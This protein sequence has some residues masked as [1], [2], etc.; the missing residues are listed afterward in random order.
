[1]NSDNS[2]SKLLNSLSPHTYSSPLKSRFNF[3][4]FNNV[5]NTYS[6]PM[7]KNN[8][9]LNKKSS[10][11]TPTGTSPAPALSTEVQVQ[12][13][14][15]GLG[16]QARSSLRA[17]SNEE[18]DSSVSSVP[19]VSSLSSSGLR[20]VRRAGKMVKRKVESCMPTQSLMRMNWWIHQRLKRSLVLFHMIYPLVLAELLG[21]L[22]PT[23]N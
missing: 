19:V 23:K 17:Q 4:C 22:S 5:S 20:Y 13:Q 16:F 21:I 11:E 10:V 8:N 6:S 18:V 3:S 12:C 1:M 15:T 7:K 9:N 14:P 2:L